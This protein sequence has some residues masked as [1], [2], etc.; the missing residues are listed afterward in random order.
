[1][2]ILIGLL[3]IGPVQGATHGYFKRSGL[4]PVE[5]ATHA[6]FNRSGIGPVKAATD[7]HFNRLALVRLKP[8]CMAILTGWPW[9]G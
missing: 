3:L 8:P 6:N 1:M 2:D 5:A 4:G 7:G 9:S